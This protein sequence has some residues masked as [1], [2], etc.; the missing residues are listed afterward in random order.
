M[1]SQN[2]LISAAKIKNFDWIR[3]P[4]VGAGSARSGSFSL[5]SPKL[6]ILAR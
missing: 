4:L 1:I 6:E 2:S 5:D 3:T